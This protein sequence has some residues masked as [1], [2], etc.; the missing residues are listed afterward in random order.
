MYSDVQIHA[1]EGRLTQWFHS[2]F[3]KNLI[4]GVL[5]GDE[6]PRRLA[7]DRLQR[8]FELRQE[9]IERRRR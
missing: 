7:A 3:A 9:F 2:A 6:R 5:V 1:I 4:E 8:A